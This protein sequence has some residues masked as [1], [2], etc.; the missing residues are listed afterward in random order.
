MSDIITINQE[1]TDNIIAL[2]RAVKQLLIRATDKAEAL[3]AY[4]KK[5][6]ITMLEL[7]NGKV[8]EFEGLEISY[9][10]ATGL[11]K[12]AKGICY[13]ESI[14]LDLAES[15]FRNLQVAIN[16][17]QTI[18]NALQSKLKYQD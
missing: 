8:I 3:G 14:V 10:S 17:Y 18:I 1:I 6:A 7:K 15:K 9:A 4:E 11:E 12:I 16:A 13:K 5:L 2:S